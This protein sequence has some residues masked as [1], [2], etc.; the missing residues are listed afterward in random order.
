MYVPLESYLAGML[1][2]LAQPKDLQ[3]LAEIRMADWSR[4][5]GAPALDAEGLT[6]AQL[7]VLAWLTG[8]RHL[9]TAAA[10]DAGRCRLLDFEDFLAN[11]ALQLARCAEFLGLEPETSA[12]LSAWPDISARYSKQPAQP[13]SAFNRRTT[14][15]RGRRTRGDEIRQGLKWAN[16]LIAGLDGLREC[17]E[18]MDAGSGPT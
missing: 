9:A 7:A 4:I 14:L 6:P 17:G 13:Y 11:P 15:Q 1:G 2:K 12:I 3:A 10:R 16:D 8:M 18:Y 5:P